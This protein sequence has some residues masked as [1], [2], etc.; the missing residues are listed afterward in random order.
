MQRFSEVAG[1]EAGGVF[2]ETD[3]AFRGDGAA[4]AGAGS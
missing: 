1:G 4:A 2:R 3:Q